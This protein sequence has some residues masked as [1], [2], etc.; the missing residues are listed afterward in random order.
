M[1]LS[2]ILY[3][4]QIEPF[5]VKAGQQVSISVI[6]LNSNIPTFVISEK[7]IK[8]ET[9]GL[10]SLAESIASSQD[11]ADKVAAFVGITRDDETITTATPTTTPATESSPPTSATSAPSGANV[12]DCAMLTVISW[13]GLLLLPLFV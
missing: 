8:A 6:N 10:V 7:V 1:V 12:I 4:Y 5:G 11:L 2:L 3:T 13:V 9:P